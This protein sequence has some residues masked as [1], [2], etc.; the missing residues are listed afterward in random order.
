[1][2]F[3]SFDDEYVRRLREGD[4]MIED[5]F[6][7]YFTELLTIKLRSKVS[8]DVLEDIRQETLMR[9]FRTIREGKLREGSK[10]GPYVNTTCTH[11]LSEYFRT[12]KVQQLDPGYDVPAP[13]N[14]E[15]ELILKQ[16]KTMLRKLLSELEPPRDRK[17]LQDLF[18]DEN[19]DEDSKDEISREHGITRENLRVIIHRATKRLIEMLG[20]DHDDDDPAPS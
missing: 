17:I 7:T 12:G 3:F 10:L 16:H 18:L 2:D 5:H 6:V 14:L 1:M 11:I 15:S 20:G 8:P 19:S 13:V 4:R 9:V